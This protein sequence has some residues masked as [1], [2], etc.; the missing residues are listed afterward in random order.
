RVV[1]IQSIQRDADRE[2]ARKEDALLVKIE[3][4]IPRLPER[5]AAAFVL[6]HFQGLTHR[7]IGAVLGC[8]EGA[9]KSHHSLA[10]GKLREWIAEEER[11]ERAEEERKR[12][13][14]REKE[15]R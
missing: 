6:R 14:R 2:E 15:S 4:M 3:T 7:E 9:S 13:E 5:Q 11:A 10:C 1:A 12:R 8:S